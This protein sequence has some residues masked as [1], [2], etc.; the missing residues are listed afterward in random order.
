MKVI[1]L[2]TN[3]R[4]KR[5]FNTLIP[6]FEK[7]SSIN[8]WNIDNEDIDNVLKIEAVESLQEKDVI[9]MIQSHGFFCEELEE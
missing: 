4:S 7:H 1:I 5:K 3:I 6:L 9:Q 8:H 2:R